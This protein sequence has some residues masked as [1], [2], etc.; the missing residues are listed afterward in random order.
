ML[1]RLSFISLYHLSIVQIEALLGSM[2][3]REELDIHRRQKRKLQTAKRKVTAWLRTY[4]PSMVNVD[5]Q[6]SRRVNE[7]KYFWNSSPQLLSASNRGK[8]FGRKMTSA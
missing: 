3:F 4:Q 6:I 2:R 8:L 5:N 7:N 1:L